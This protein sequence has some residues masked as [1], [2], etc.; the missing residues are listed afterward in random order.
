[1]LPV[2]WGIFAISAVGGFLVLAAYWLDVQD[3]PDL[4]FRQRLAWSVAI[5]GFPLAIP[6]YAF[7]GGAGWPP[8]LRAASFVPALALLLFFGFAFGYFT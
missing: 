4:T 2:I 3:R 1:M 6:A 5:L 7:L 8:F